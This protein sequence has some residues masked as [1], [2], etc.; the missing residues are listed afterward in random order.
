MASKM[1]G[2][3]SIVVVAGI[4]GSIFILN[5]P[6]LNDYSRWLNEK[7]HAQCLNYGCEDFKLVVTEDGQQKTIIMHNM[8]G[9]YNPGL[10][11]MTKQAIYRTLGQSHYLLDLNVRGFLGHFTIVKVTKK[12]PTN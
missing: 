10:F 2:I 11:V 5:K 6:S 1:W 8:H 4:I 12:L 7:Y 3:F 9:D